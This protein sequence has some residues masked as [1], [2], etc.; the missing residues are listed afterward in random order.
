MRDEG[1][2]TGKQRQGILGGLTGTERY[3][4][5]RKVSRAAPPAANKLTEQELRDLT[6]W[7]AQGATDYQMGELLGRNHST[8]ATWRKR[9][10]LEANGHKKGS[11]A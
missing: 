7:H 4:L 10:G 8:V 9:N 11:A 3:S 6:E 5:K 2:R 1:T